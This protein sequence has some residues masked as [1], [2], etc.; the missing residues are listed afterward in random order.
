MRRIAVVCM[1]VLAAFA[2]FAT[3][4]ED[5]NS[6]TQGPGSETYSQV[7][8]NSDRDGFAASKSWK[9][10][11]SGKGVNGDDYLFAR[12]AKK[13]AHALFKVPIPDDGVYAVYVRWPEAR[14]LNDRTPVGVETAYGTKWTEVDQRKDGGKWVRVGEF[15]MRQDEEF[16][17][18]I[19]HN[20]KGKGKV[21]ADAVKVEKVSSYE[22]P[23]AI[24]STGS[25]TPS[26]GTRTASATG[27]NVA[28]TAISLANTYRKNGVK[29]KYGACTSKLMSCTCFTKR[30]YANYGITLPMDEPGQVRRGVA[31]S[32][33]ALRA[34]DLVY[35]KEN[36]P[37]GP[38]THVGVYVGVN[39]KTGQQ[40]ISHASSYF[41]TT[42]TSQMRYIKG[43]A[44]ARRLV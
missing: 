35:F 8:D 33:A 43:Y 24:N 31:V 15:E 22:D 44:G 28:R 41:G 1:A 32:R 6:E 38:I 40:M 16:P 11:D 19:S 7:V 26:E 23:A 18:R 34:G 4:R 13:G 9:K 39:T 29:Y 20:T 14:G 30:V 27:A 12:P 2:V 21:V 5:A 3:V 36:G 10:S 25:A 42:V 17:I 37:S